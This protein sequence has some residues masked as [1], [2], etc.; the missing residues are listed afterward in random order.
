M[1]TTQC[2]GCH[3]Q[4]SNWDCLGE[5]EGTGCE[6]VNCTG[7]VACPECGVGDDDDDFFGYARPID[8]VTPSAAIL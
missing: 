5:N 1:A 6:C 7:S 8:V 2:D 3:G 4:G